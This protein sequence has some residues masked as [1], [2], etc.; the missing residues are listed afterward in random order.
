MAAKKP[1]NKKSSKGMP[2]WLM[3]KDNDADDKGKKKVAPKGKK[4]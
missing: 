4:K 1:A 2:P 3:K